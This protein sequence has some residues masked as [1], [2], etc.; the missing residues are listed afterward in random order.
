MQ[1]NFIKINGI[2]L[3]FIEQ[4]PKAEKVIFFI[5]GNSSS[6]GIWLKQF[7]SELLSGYR[8]I[9]FDLP[10]HGG[11]GSLNGT[12]IEYS[13]P[14][15]GEIMAGA[16]K[17]SAGGGKFIIA[18]LS[19]GTNIVAEMLTHTIAHAGVIAIGSCMI[20][21]DYTME[22][23]FKPGIDIHAA[24]ADEVSYDEL[25]QYAKLT[26]I[27]GAEKEWQ[28]FDENY[29]CVKDNF[30]SKMFAT[31]A[32]GNLNNQVGL[33]QQQSVPAL[34]VFGEEEK[35][36]DTGYFDNAGLQLWKNKT[37]KIP[38][39]GHLVNIDQPEKLNE[40]ISEFAL[41]VFK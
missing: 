6:S 7:K 39:A 12:G 18:G 17:E 25:R 16:L 20:G 1:Q 36:C 23:V 10:A 11:S 26:F 32:E 31:V 38:R 37:Y 9:A 30:R 13:L 22:R 29:R 33:L 14:I 28:Q 21:G 41:G 4:N 8:L 2:T 34:I 27:S 15:L 3:A 5:H 24:F 40:L 19:L 35:I